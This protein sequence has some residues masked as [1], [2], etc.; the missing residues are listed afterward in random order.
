MKKTSV[1]P[2]ILI[3]TV[4]LVIPIVF[5]VVSF[6]STDDN[7]QGARTKNG[8]AGASVLVSSKY[9]TW[10]LVKY[11]CQTREECVGSLTSGRV[12]DTTSGGVTDR[13][14]VVIKYSKD[15]D[16]YKFLKVFVKSGWGSSLREFQVSLAGNASGSYVEDV[17]YNGINYKVV[18]VPIDIISGSLMEIA[19]FSDL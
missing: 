16:S 19:E 3:V 14:S 8:D 1:L 17:V 18:I 15:W 9:G 12:L 13:Q 7:I 2:L 11:L 5:W 4:F 6:R 10:D